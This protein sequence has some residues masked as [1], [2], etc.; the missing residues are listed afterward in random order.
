M[1]PKSSMRVLQ[2]PVMRASRNLKRLQKGSA[3]WRKPLNTAAAAGRYDQGCSQCQIP[4]EGKALFLRVGLL[5]SILATRI[6]PGPCGRLS[7]GPIS[8][9]RGVIFQHNGHAM[10]T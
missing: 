5:R 9:Q 3:D 6:P 4:A 10:L 7:P 8:L 1:A 2:Q